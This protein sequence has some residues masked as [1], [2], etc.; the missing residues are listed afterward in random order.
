VRHRHDHGQLQ[1]L[2]VVLEEAGGNNKAIRFYAFWNN[3]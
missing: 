3:A 1:H 2:W